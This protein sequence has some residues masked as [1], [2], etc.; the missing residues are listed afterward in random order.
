MRTQINTDKNFLHKELCYQLL[1]CFF[2]IRK[3]YGP[4]QKESIYV[5]LIIEWLKEHKIPF[6]KEKL[7]K[8]YSISSGKVIGAYKPDIVVDNKITLEIKSSRITTKRDEKQL[9]YYLRNSKYEVGYLVNFSTPK[10]YI[11]RI[12]YTNN[13]KPFL[14]SNNSV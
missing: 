10:L 3:N 9:Y 11:K 12:I 8:I 4:G 14:R 6:E 2:N 1:G 7:I 13:R 5:N